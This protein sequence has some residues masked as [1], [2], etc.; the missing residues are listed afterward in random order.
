MIKKQL[1]SFLSF[2]K[3][4]SNGL[5]VFCLLLLLIVFLPT[6]SAKLFPS[7]VFSSAEFK[8][9]IA[10]FR[11]SAEPT[12][13]YSY[14]N[15]KEEESE[16]AEFFEPTYFKFNPNNLP[17]EEWSKLGLSAKQIHVI[18]NYEA[19]GGK[20]YQ[21]EDLRKIYSISAKDYER[22]EPYIDIPQRY[23][24]KNYNDGRQKEITYNFKVIEL[25]EADSSQL[26]LLP[27][28][29]P[30]FASRIMKWKIR[31][32]GFYSKEQLREI[33]GLDST[34]YEGLKNQIK[35]DPTKIIKIN[36]NTATF[37]E[38]KKHPYLSYKQ[39]NAIIQY[40]KQHGAYKNISDMKNILILNEDILR[41]I[42]PY[43]DF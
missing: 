8:Q 27:G 7:Q 23:E 39:I 10:D 38:L 30:A 43:L 5:L 17:E 21:K 42:A 13:T 22:L 14:K 41:K 35:V 4:E 6:I 36:I 25:N 18:K 40:R 26:E 2:S 29:G 16:D 28:I 12:H 24:N 19:K 37:E 31:L 32:G 20:F 15:Y 3:K 9:E 1:K 11:N 33:Y 34:K